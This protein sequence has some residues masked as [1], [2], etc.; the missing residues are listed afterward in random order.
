MFISILLLVDDVFRFFSSG[1]AQNS[2]FLTFCLFSLFLSLTSLSLG[3]SR[4]FLVEEVNLNFKFYPDSSLLIMKFFS[5]FLCLLTR[6]F[7]FICLYHILSFRCFIFLMVYLFKISFVY[8]NYTKL[9]EH[10]RKGFCIFL[11]LEFLPLLYI[12][13][14]FIQFP[15]YRRDQKSRALKVFAAKNFFYY[16]TFLFDFWFLNLIF[17]QYFPY[18]NEES[19]QYLC[20]FYYL[21]NNILLGALYVL[22]IVFNFCLTNKSFWIHI[23]FFTVRM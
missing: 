11:G 2:F 8:F 16:V 22:E 4:F 15:F 14:F 6:P 7:L 18:K 20:L 21:L 19:S 5:N 10:V 9:S 13:L 23:S 12:P 3:F 1:T 17:F